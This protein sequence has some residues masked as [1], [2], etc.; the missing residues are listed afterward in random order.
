MGKPQSEAG[1]FRDELQTLRKALEKWAFLEFTNPRQI[2]T[3]KLPWL[4][5]AR[6]SGSLAARAQQTLQLVH[7]FFD[8]FEIQVNGGEADVGYLV[9]FP[10][11]VHH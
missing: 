10:E 5:G 3:A 9:Q 2:R 1:L 11:P 4:P 7:E 8:V 6:G